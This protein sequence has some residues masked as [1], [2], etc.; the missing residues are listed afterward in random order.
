MQSGISSRRRSVAQSAFLLFALV[1][2]AIRSVVP[3]GWMPGTSAEGTPIVLCTAQGLVE[4]FLDDDG[5]PIDSSKS[6]EATQHE[7]PCIFAA[8]AHFTS[9]PLPAGLAPT[10]AYV[11]IEQSYKEA[12]GLIRNGS[13]P[14]QARAPP[15]IS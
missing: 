4:V 1:A 7:A 8:S 5:K 6:H 3:V 9:P 10:P 12:A 11:V 14:A 15:A 13:N 2:V